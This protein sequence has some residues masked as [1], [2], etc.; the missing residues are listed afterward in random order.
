MIHGNLKSK[1]ILLDRSLHPYI[2]DHGMHLLLNPKAGQEMLDASALQGYKAP[3]LMKIKDVCESTDIYSLGV[4][5]L[6]LLT[7]K[8]PINGNPSSSQEL[9]LPNAVRS[10]VLRRRI[11]DLYHPDLLMNETSGQRQ[12]TEDRILKLVQLAIS[13]CSPSPSFRPPAK[14]VLRKIEEIGR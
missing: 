13:C 11:T 5:L 6:E 2:S 7:G 14:E 9:Y 12:F 4:V 8:K 1:N 10:A 3:E